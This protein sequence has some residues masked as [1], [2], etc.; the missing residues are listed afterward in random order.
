MSQLQS[1]MMVLEKQE[2]KNIYVNCYVQSILVRML[3]Y[4]T[5]IHTQ[6]FVICYTSTYSWV[7]YC[8]VTCFTVHTII[9][10]LVLGQ[11]QQGEASIPKNKQR[12]ITRG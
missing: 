1:G 9:E 12:K 3:E 10:A 2:V 4:W 7:I 5:Q 8:R 11:F 6:V